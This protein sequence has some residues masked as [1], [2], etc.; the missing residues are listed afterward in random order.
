MLRPFAFTCGI[1]RPPDFGATLRPSARA[2]EPDPGSGPA[3]ERRERGE[4]GLDVGALLEA[5]HGAAV[6]EQVELHVAAAAH[7]LLGAVGFGPGLVHP[8]TDD[9]GIDAQER[10]AHSAGEGEVAFE[11][12]A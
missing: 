1:A 12:A 5:E 11:I 9:L 10:L 4:H 8:V 2:V 7:Q 6:V 3:D